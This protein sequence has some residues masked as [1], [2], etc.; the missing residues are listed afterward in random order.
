MDKEKLA[1][2]EKEKATALSRAEAAEK[3]VEALKAKLAKAESEGEKL[4]KRLADNEAKATA[5]ARDLD[6][7]RIAAACD[8]AMIPNADGKV[9][10]PADVERI[11]HLSR[12]LLDAGVES[13][14]VL[15]RNENGTAEEA[16]VGA[17]EWA[18][19]ELAQLSRTVALGRTGGARGPG[20]NGGAGVE[21]ATPD[22]KTRDGKV[23]DGAS[24]D[25][26]RLATKLAKDLEIDYGEAQVR[27]S[28]ESARI[29]VEER[30]EE[31]EALSQADK[32]L[33]EEA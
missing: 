22:R 20:E 14:I 15:S 23:I 7:Q 26:D 6:S 21:G 28:R 19:H 27:L 8:R 24:I 3:E 29:A 18:E 31:H 2:L 4:S 17:V 13:R 9:P 32:A 12:T 1:A 5:L 11:R 10:T 16:M 33:R 30:I 25:F